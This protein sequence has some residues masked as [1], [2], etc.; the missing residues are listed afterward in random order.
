V[1]PPTL[2]SC[3]HRQARF[4]AAEAGFDKASGIEAVSD[5]FL[6]HNIPDA[7]GLLRKEQQFSGSA[8]VGSGLFFAYRF[9][10]HCSCG[11][12]ER[13]LSCCVLLAAH[14]FAIAIR[15][16]KTQKLPAAAIQMVVVLFPSNWPDELEC[17]SRP[18]S[19]MRTMT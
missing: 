17:H 19:P 18:G 1:K 16:S 10:R 14:F 9:C 4:G 7:A 12:L 8:S 6:A 3:A 2:K 5:V 13:L 11:L 15:T